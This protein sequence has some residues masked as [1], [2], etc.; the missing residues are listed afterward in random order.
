MKGMNVSCAGWG[1]EWGSREMDASLSELRG[2]GVEWIAIHPYAQIELDGSIRSREPLDGS[3]PEYLVRAAKYVRARG[4][5]LFYNPH[6]AYW[7][8]Y[9]WRG[10]ISYGSNEGAWARFFKD[11]R[12][13]IV[14]QAR[15]AEEL[16]APLFGIGVELDGTV[17]RPEWRELIRAVRKVYRGRITY[18]ANWDSFTKVPFWGELDDIGVQAYFPVA[19]TDARESWAP[20]LAALREVSLRWDRRVIFTEIGYNRTPKA[21]TEPWLEVMDDTPAAR[22]LR[23]RLMVGAL[24]V[25]E[26]NQDLVRGAFW[27]KWIPGFAPWE[28][29]FRMRDDEARRALRRFWNRSMR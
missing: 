19:G 18:A 16:G 24:E 25:L 21:A 5:K 3:A 14:A 10:E 20:H 1:L 22:E 15:F 4:Q 6:L 8:R 23:E 29:D 13:F 27:W 28:K 9:S 7:G 11:Y 2:L 17:H 12:S 26:S